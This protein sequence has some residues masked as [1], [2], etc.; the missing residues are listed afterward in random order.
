MEND[1]YSLTDGDVAELQMLFKKIF[2]VIISREEAYEEGVNLL[3]LMR[4]L[5]RRIYK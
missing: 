2:G 3:N 4:V 5:C 1:K